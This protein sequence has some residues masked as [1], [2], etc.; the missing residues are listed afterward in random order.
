MELPAVAPELEAAVVGVIAEHHTAL[1]EAAAV[2][3]PAQKK[4]RNLLLFAPCI[5]QYRLYQCVCMYR[6]GNQQEQHGFQYIVGYQLYL[7]CGA[8]NSTC[9]GVVSLTVLQWK[10]CGFPH[11]AAAPMCAYNIS[12]TNQTLPTAVRW[13]SYKTHHQL[14]AAAGTPRNPLPLF[15]RV[16]AEPAAASLPP[17]Q[18]HQLVYTTCGAG[19]VQYRDGAGV[20]ALGG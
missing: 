16:S 9:L 11:T 12:S 4:K 3:L 13:R 17:R 19:C 1:V 6:R 2:K 5:Q 18:H 15:Q 14:L 7:A 10:R 20:F 8:W